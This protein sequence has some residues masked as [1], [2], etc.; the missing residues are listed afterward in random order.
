MARLSR[1]VPFYLLFSSNFSASRRIKPELL[2]LLLNIGIL[3]LFSFAIAIL[4]E[5]MLKLENC[6][7]QLP[8]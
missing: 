5:F 8:V 6:S 7:I 4:C 3:A 1:D 2:E